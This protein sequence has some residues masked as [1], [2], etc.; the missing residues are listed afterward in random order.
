M[1][2]SIAVCASTSCNT[3]RSGRSIN[4][5]CAGLQILSFGVIEMA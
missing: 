1:N 3:T 4:I 2:C 5:A